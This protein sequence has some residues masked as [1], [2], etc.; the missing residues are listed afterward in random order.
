MQPIVGQSSNARYFQRQPA[1]VAD[2]ANRTRPICSGGASP[3][4]KSRCRCKASANAEAIQYRQRR[5]GEPDSPLGPKDFTK[6]LL[7]S[8]VD[9]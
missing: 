6:P 9:P 7:G 3:A 5:R 8:R 4:S 2:A 1:S